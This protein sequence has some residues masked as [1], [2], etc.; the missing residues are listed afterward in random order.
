MRLDRKSQNKRAKRVGG[1]MMYVHNKHAL[2]CEP[3][4]DLDVSNEDI[5]SQWVLIQRPHCKI[6]VICNIYR[7]PNG[8]LVK[9]SR[10]LC[11]GNQPE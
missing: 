10:K 4:G 9:T 5:E 6:V 8:N 3:L 7:P 2:H 11:E 1:L